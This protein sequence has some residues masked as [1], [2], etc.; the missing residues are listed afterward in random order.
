MP[1]EIRFISFTTD[2]FLQAARLYFRRVGEPLPGAIDAVSIVDDCRIR[3]SLAQTVGGG[4]SEMFLDHN[5]I[6]SILVFYCIEQGI[7]LPSKSL[8][9][10]KLFGDNICLMVTKNVPMADLDRIKLNLPD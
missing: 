9:T 7:P 10:L 3:L 2:E 1:R 5:K 8:R 6:G 4:G